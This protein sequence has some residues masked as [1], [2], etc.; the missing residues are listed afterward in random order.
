[1]NLKTAKQSVDALKNPPTGLLSVELSWAKGIGF[2]EAYEQQENN[3][4]P[5]LELIQFI[6]TGY[7]GG[8][9]RAAADKALQ[10]LKERREEAI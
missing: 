5:L 3:Y 9:M 4:K 10:I 7:G 8:D 2:L 6:S 1:M